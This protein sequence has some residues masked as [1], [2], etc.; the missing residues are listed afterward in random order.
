MHLF[1]GI[2]KTPHR[3]IVNSMTTSA[4]AVDDV[5]TPAHALGG[6]LHA[7]RDRL[8]PSD[9]GLSPVGRRR[10]HG[11]RREELA[12]LAAVSVDY[13]VR[14]EQG[15]SH[16]PSPQVVE[17]LA[18]A[19]QLNKF[20]RD[21]LYTVSGLLPPPTG[22]VS[23]HIPPSV[24][25]LIAR[26]GDIPLAVF[27]A[28]WTL[29]M[30]TPLWASLIGDPLDLDIDERNLVHFVFLA[31]GADRHPFWPVR[32]ERGEREFEAALVSDLR[33][34]AAAL[35]PWPRAPAVAPIRGGVRRLAPLP[36]GS[37]PSPAPR[38]RR[39]GGRPR[40]RRP[41][42]PRRASRVGRTGRPRAR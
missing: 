40:R 16:S 31:D 11:L 15:R 27:A 30:W 38:A 39:S 33:I 25:R 5:T 21:Y 18:R 6:A 3:A 23:T 28:D 4:H 20:E 29:V 19:L 26:L 12:A 41:A 1:E 13:L 32:S 37:L 14:L 22:S 10:A 9:V 34:A 24:Q 42:P 7:W 2:C 17:S 36:R 8:S 35:P